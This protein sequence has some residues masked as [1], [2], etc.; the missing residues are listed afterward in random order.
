MLDTYRRIL[1]VPGSRR[2]SGAAFV[3]RLPISMVGIG[4]VLLVQDATGSYGLA[5]AVSATYVA[6]GAVMAVLQGRWLDRH[7]QSRVLLPMVA[8]FT[9]SLGLLVVAVASDWPT[10]T[11]YLLA[12]VGG[13]SLPAAGTCVRAR[14]SYVLRERPADVQTAFALEAVVDEAVFMLG[15]IVVTVLATA[16]SPSV[17]VVTAVVAGLLGTGLLAAQ[18]STEPP[19]HP[20]RRSDGPRVPL[21][22]RTLLPVAV[23]MFSL[24]ALFGGAEVV[25]V[26]FAEEQG[27]Q[28]YAGPLL[29]L[30]ALGS[31]LAGLVTG[32]VVWTRPPVDRVRFGALGMCLAMAPLALVDSVPLMGVLLLLGGFA[33]APT[34][35]AATSLVERSVP[36]SR[37]A[38]GMSVL[39]MGVVAGVGP[40]AAL[41][42]L[43]VDRSGASAAYLVSFAAGA[44]AAVVAL[45]IPRPR[46]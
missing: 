26:A 30:W 45:L 25:T 44:L 18:R 23:V 31:L 21:P 7:G 20:R 32:A 16:V 14:W 2:F 22:W 6:A 3:A 34:M 8:V 5:G 41:S 12:A 17:G 42:G 10:V 39:H 40:G 13:G 29:A 35:I 19:A 1:T 38:E 33:I 37:L 28:A 24:G 15:P 27:S 43:V 36:A 46:G 4:I 9:V 11:T